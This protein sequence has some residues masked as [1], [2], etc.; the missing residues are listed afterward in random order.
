MALEMTR[1]ADQ[2]ARN[3]LKSQAEY[4]ELRAV[5]Y[6]QLRAAQQ[7]REDAMREAAAAGLSRRTIAHMTG[8]SHTRVNQILS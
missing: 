4:A 5:V 3:L 8:L 2:V 6:A 7:K 1:D